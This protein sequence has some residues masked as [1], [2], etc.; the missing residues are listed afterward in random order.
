MCRSPPMPCALPRSGTA[1][2]LRKL[3][4]GPTGVGFPTRPRQDCVPTPFEEVAASHRKRVLLAIAA[5][6]TVARLPA[7]AGP[8]SG[9]AEMRLVKYRAKGSPSTWRIA[10]HRGGADGEI[11]GG[12]PQPAGDILFEAWRG[13]AHARRALRAIRGRD[14]TIW[15]AAGAADIGPHPP[16]LSTSRRATSSSEPS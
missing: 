13:I 8:I 11:R 16:R 9:R 12:I 3:G 1:Y 15:C 2:F 14:P 7:P 4:P 10:P 6:I 5:L